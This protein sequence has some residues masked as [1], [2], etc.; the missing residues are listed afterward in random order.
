MNRKQ[1]RAQQKFQRAAAK[2]TRQPGH[3]ELLARRQALLQANL[4]LIAAAQRRFHETEDGTPVVFLMDLQDPVA[5]EMTYG[6]R[7]QGGASREELERLQEN[8]PKMGKIPTAVLAIDADAASQLIESV[9][10]L[11]HMVDRRNPP[12]SDVPDLI[13]S[14][15]STSSSDTFVVIWSFGKRFVRIPVMKGDH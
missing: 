10:R 7:S 11:L 5:R 13:R 1:R 3:E 9:Q 8:A 15:S 6:M 4:P 2:Q 12:A 14:L